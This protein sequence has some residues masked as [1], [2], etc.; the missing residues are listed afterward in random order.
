MVR[1]TK[2]RVIV[3]VVAVLIG[4]AV[5][6]VVPSATAI[7]EQRSVSRYACVL[8]EVRQYRDAPHNPNEWA[9]IP[10]GGG[11]KCD[12]RDRVWWRPWVGAMLRG[13]RDRVLVAC[14]LRKHPDNPRAFTTEEAD[15]CE[16][17]A[18]GWVSIRLHDWAQ[19]FAEVWGLSG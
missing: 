8:A 15:G 1:I 7:E 14:F 5:W 12:H 3:L 18:D 13:G 6:T 19:D 4:V 17:E 10:V 9:G 2:R 11:E 16:R